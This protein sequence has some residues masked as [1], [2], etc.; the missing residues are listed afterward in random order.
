MA[1]TSFHN[2]SVRS[3]G[4]P[5]QAH[6][7][8]LS[9]R[10]LLQSATAGAALAT[11]GGLAPHR[12]QAQAGKLIFLCPPWGVPPEAA[13]LAGFTTQSGI[14][15]EVQSVPYDQV[16]SKVETASL[17]GVAPA[18]VIYLSSSEAPT[19]M[20]IPG[21]LEP[22][23]QCFADQQ[24]NPAEIDR[25]SSWQYEDQHYGVTVY[26]QM[27][28]MDY[29][30]ERLK[31][32]GFT[33]PPTSWTEMADM[34]RAIKQQGID[35]YPLSMGI[36]NISWYIMS[37]SLGDQIATEDFTAT[38]AE[39]DSGGRQAMRLLLGWFQEGLITPE[40]LSR[41][42]PHDLYLAGIGTFH[43][44]WQGALAVM[45]NPETSQQAPN[46]RYM[47]M[48]DQHFTYAGDAGLGI[49][50]FSEAKA[51]ACQFINWYLS[52]PVQTAIYDA[53]GL[54][55]SRPTV[56]QELSTAGKIQQY[57]LEQEQATYVRPLPIAAPW[58]V[59]FSDFVTE[60]LKRGAQGEFDAD[61][62]IDQMA[63]RWE[64]LKS[65]QG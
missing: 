30:E 6:L 27:V 59:E 19:T 29:N 12:A 45:N 9:R 40:M 17:A 34:A 52:P 50:A 60:S 22:L 31:A 16:Q 21:L 64:T 44:S 42:T 20:I 23:D 65:E 56:Q 58:W 57:E 53:Y 39:P 13:N 26:V 54:V 2:A 15:V 1:M 35:E 3:S 4:A 8:S 37:L 49:S 10:Q 63:E 51:Q 55:P 11:A 38:F 18:D 41:D 25:M 61:T 43:Q 36:F 7:S 24:I 62:A 28:M 5:A 33:A 32:G 48:P 14:E 46:V 47:L